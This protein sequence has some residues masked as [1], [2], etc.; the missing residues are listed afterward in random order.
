MIRKCYIPHIAKTWKSIKL[1]DKA[2]AKSYTCR[3]MNDGR[4]IY[5]PY[6]PFKIEKDK[7]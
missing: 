4:V 1:P 3:I 6:D 5:T 2:D 7:K